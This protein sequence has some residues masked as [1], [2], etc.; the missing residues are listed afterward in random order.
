MVLSRRDLLQATYIN[1]LKTLL[2]NSSSSRWT[3][4][5]SIGLPY[6]CCLFQANLFHLH[7]SASVPTYPHLPACSSLSLRMFTCVSHPPQDSFIST[8]FPTIEM[9]I[10]RFAAARSLDCCASR[11]IDGMNQALVAGVTWF[12]VGMDWIKLCCL[13]VGCRMVLL[14]F[15][16]WSRLH[17]QQL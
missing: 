14:L 4:F 7:S 5:R 13:C 16:G 2:F 10:R 11:C 17:R 3:M 8:R 12:S 1:I 15:A 9:Y 6:T